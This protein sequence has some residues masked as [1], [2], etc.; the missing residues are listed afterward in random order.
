MLKKSPTK[1]LAKTKD[2][3]I[4]SRILDVQEIT[5]GQ[6]ALF[7]GRS[8]TGK[9]ALSSTYPK[10]MLVLDIKERG[11]ETIRNVEG[12]KVLQVDQWEEIEESYWYLKKGG[13]GFV[14]VSLDQITTMQDVAM[15]KVRRDDGLSETDL[16]SKRNWGRISGLLKTWLLNFRDLRDDGINVIFLAHDRSNIPDDSEEDQ[17]DPNIGARIMPSV[18]SFLNGAVDVIGNTFIQ[19]RMEG[20]KGAKV[21]K[22]SYGL[23]VGPHAFYSTKLRVPIG[24]GIEVPDIILNPSYEKLQRISR[25]EALSNKPKTLKR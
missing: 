19:E 7:Y 6:T 2:D 14:T 21:R 10:K 22:V 15:D 17:L 4:E 8:S 23:R 25:G 18:S 13:H 5:S 24:S 12:I 11:T 20:P 3:S 16:I 1:K 9:T